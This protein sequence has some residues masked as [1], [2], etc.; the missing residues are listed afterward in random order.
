MELDARA[1]ANGENQEGKA[2]LSAKAGAKAIKATAKKVGKKSLG[3]L[4][5]SSREK[6]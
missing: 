5:N 6:S 4:H 2:T 3:R 1:V